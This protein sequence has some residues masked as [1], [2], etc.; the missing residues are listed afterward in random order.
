MKITCPRLAALSFSAGMCAPATALGQ[1]D[2][3]DP[4]HLVSA[5]LAT[6]EIP[7]LPCGFALLNVAGHKVPFIFPCP[8]EGQPMSGVWV[9]TTASSD[10]DTTAC[11]ACAFTAGEDIKSSFKTD[12]TSPAAPAL[13]ASLPVWD[14]Q[15]G[16][17]QQYQD[18]VAATSGLLPSSPVQPLLDRL[19]AARAVLQPFATLAGTTIKPPQTGLSSTWTRAFAPIHGRHLVHALRPPELIPQPAGWI[20][21][22][23]PDPQCLAELRWR[24]ARSY[25][26][27]RQAALSAG[28]ARLS[29]GSWSIGDALF[30]SFG[31]VAP[32][33]RFAPPVKDLD[34]SSAN[35]F[36]IPL[37]LGGDVTPAR[38]PILPNFG[39]LSH[40]LVWLTG[41]AEVFSDEDFGSFFLPPTECFGRGVCKPNPQE[42]FRKRFRN[43][44]HV[45]VLAGTSASAILEVPDVLLATF[46]PASLFLNGTITID[47]GLVEDGNPMTGGAVVDPSAPIPGHRRSGRR[48]APTCWT[49]S[50][51][52]VPRPPMRRSGVSSAAAT[53]CGRSRAG[54]QL[55][56]GPSPP[57]PP[58]GRRSRSAPS[59]GG[60]T[61][62]TGR[63]PCATASRKP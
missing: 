12:T 50:G 51:S 20:A 16:L 15:G 11:R 27:M 54:C 46:G 33:L 41:D 59:R 7:T 62:M 49:C 3:V 6:S 52:R 31:D 30:W 35:A 14:A 53:S 43:L 2:A 4:F 26:A 34:A 23:Y 1:V 5:D 17:R 47:S 25:C 18:V 42:G 32:S 19:E 28:G 36:A 40:P 8:L 24:G 61:T 60:A 29:L 44:K 63:S 21:H 58:W 38:G 45:D 37:L 13:V 55:P 48:H 57:R 39:D 22:D 56:P 9:K 10:A